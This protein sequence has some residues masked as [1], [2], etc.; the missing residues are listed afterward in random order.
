VDPFTPNE[1][2]VPMIV[3]IVL[4]VFPGRIRLGGIIGSAAARRQVCCQNGCSRIEVERHMALEVD[5]VAGLSARGEANRCST[6]R[7]CGFDRLVDCRG[8]NRGAIAFCAIGLYIEH[9]SCACPPAWLLIVRERRVSP[10]RGPCLPA[11]RGLCEQWSFV[12][13]RAAVGK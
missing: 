9:G 2:I 8:I 1:T 5:R 6:L 4:I 7:A 11:L 10:R 12:F 13:L 3:A